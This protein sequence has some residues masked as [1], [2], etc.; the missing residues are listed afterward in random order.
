M[1]PFLRNQWYTAAT[2]AELGEKGEKSPRLGELLAD[3]LTR[4]LIY[5]RRPHDGQEE[6]FCLMIESLE[7]W[8][9][10]HGYPNRARAV[11]FAIGT[12]REIG[13]SAAHSASAERDLP[14]R[15]P[16]QKEDRAAARIR[17]TAAGK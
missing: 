7:F 14:G 16:V 3:G 2:S 8:A 11:E 6:D 9:G 1:S 4:Y 10:M 5:A 13:N 12:R 17:S 15:K